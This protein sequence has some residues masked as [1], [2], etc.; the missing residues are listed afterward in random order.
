MAW[1]DADQHEFRRGPGAQPRFRCLGYDRGS[2]MILGSLL[3]SV[4]TQGFGWASVFYVNV[5]RNRSG[6]PSS[7]T[8]GPGRDTPS[9]A[10]LPVVLA[11]CRRPADLV[12]RDREA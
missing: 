8:T 11:L 6:A 9:R 5:P 2:G 7:A 10:S 12:L 3:G 4:L 1:A